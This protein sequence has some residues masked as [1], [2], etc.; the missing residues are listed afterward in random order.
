MYLIYSWQLFA[1][2]L[3]TE[4]ITSRCTYSSLQDLPKFVIQIIT[5]DYFTILR[6]SCMW[7]LAS[8]C[9]GYPAYIIAINFINKENSDQCMFCLNK[10]TN[11]SIL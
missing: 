6:V 8:D 11:L 10:K 9:N 5:C 4:G 7:M 3:A 1:V 2:I